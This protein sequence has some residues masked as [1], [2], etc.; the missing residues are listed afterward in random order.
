L[1]LNPENAPDLARAMARDLVIAERFQ[2]AL[3][4]YQE[5]AA[6]DP[7]D[8]EAYSPDVADLPPASRLPEKAREAQRQGS[9]H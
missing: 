7:G 9:Q 3:Q 2:D 8:A 6:D 5:L 1:E 4:V